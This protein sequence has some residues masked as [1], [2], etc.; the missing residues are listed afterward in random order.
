MNGG[1]PHIFVVTCHDIGQ[2]LGCYGVESVQSP[3][4]DR[5]AAEGTRFDRAFCTAPQCSPSRASLATGRYA[6]NNGVMGLS[7][8]GWDLYP[9]EKHA[10]ARMAEHG[11]ETHLFGLQHVTQ[12]AHRLGFQY[13][14]AQGTGH[15]GG[16]E[17][18]TAR[19]VSVAVE[20]FLHGPQPQSPLY[21]EINFFEPHR[22][23]DFGGV[24]ADT[25]A[26]VWVPPYLPQ[27]PEAREEMAA[28]QGAIRE[29]DH[30][31][32][33]ILDALDQA[34]LSLRSLVIFN[35]DHGLPMP[36]AKCTL[37]DPGIS[38]AQIVR[39]PEGGVPAGRVV[40]EMVSNLDVLP[41]ILEA[42]RC[43]IPVEV[44]G[45]S[46]LAL[47]RNEPH[48]ARKEIYAEKNF[49]SYYD[50][51]RCIRTERF[52]YIRNFEVNFSI[53][54]P[55]DI[56]QGPIFCSDP[57]RYTSQRQQLIELY[58][59][60]ADPLEQDNLAGHPEVADIQWELD[61]RLWSWM[62]ETQDP[63]LQ[64]PIASPRY[65]MAMQERLATRQ[66]GNGIDVGP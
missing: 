46:F 40:T 26:G 39:W 20:E 15:G 17:S 55:G 36:R 64:G 22:P 3:N 44:Q 52:K 14:H 60:S 38:I 35:A 51:M 54:V 25:S 8:L 2:H 53:E 48:R 30:A 56:Q 57:G 28:L 42:A 23:Y 34:D 63:L 41:T 50:P 66:A 19:K 5:L 11:Y 45:I 9:E 49:H 43:P 12:D 58:D 61:Q 47:L 27:I 33:C 65:H 18:S 32:G 37:Y 21:V 10:A 1:K 4:L 7:H 13:L 16:T 29:V 6:H 59:L 31:I 24:E 62:E